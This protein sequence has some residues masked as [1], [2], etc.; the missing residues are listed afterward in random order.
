MTFLSYGTH[1]LGPRAATHQLELYLDLICP[2]SAKQLQGVYDYVLPLIKDGKLDLAVIIRQIPQPWHSS[3]TLV[4]EAA[5]AVAQVLAST[6]HDDFND[7][8]VNEQ[9]NKFFKQLMDDQKEFYDEPC[10]KESPE[11][12]RQR[13]ADKASDFVDRNS[14]L[15]KV[16]TGKSNGGTAVTADLKQ[17][18]KYGRQNG[19]HVTPTVAL[20]GLIDPSVSSSF[21]KDDWTKFF[22]DKGLLKN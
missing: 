14:F 15:E 4:H 16:K 19:V 10:S 7:R 12:T 20:N 6:K 17:A 11:Q 9:F 18:I 21:T 3:S 5:I 2:F 8:Q 1:I 22:E 13:L